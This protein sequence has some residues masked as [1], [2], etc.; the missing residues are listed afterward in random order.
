NSVAGVVGLTADLL[1]GVAPG[2]RRRVRLQRDVVLPVGF[3]LYGRRGAALA[4]VTVVASHPHALGQCRAWLRRRLPKA[5]EHPVP[6]TA[7]ALDL[8][9]KDLVGRV[10]AVAAQ[11]RTRPDVV[12]LARGVA[13][14]PDA[15][16]RFVVVGTC[17]PEG[18][19]ARSVL[20]WLAIVV[21][22]GFAV[23]FVASQ[24]RSAAPLVPLELFASP[25]FRGANQAAALVNFGTLGLLYLL[26]ITFSEVL[27]LTA[28]HS[29]W[30]IAPL[31][32]AYAVAS[33]FAGKIARRAGPRLP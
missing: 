7:A 20:G 21:G 22:A 13:D 15:E 33:L 4:D 2:G 26:G 6:S 27:G 32:A 24:R 28:T 10:A 31:F 11:G 1:A 12:R 14:R 9:G 18:T 30:R 19:G 3:D 5:V 16:T 17:L 29:G 8:V 25:T 23:A